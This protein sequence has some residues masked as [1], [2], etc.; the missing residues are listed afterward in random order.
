[1]FNLGCTI[2]GVG[3]ENSL[4]P[5]FKLINRKQVKFPV[6]LMLSKTKSRREITCYI[7]MI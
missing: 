5:F 1:M 6:E 4:T 3:E 7:L 2:N